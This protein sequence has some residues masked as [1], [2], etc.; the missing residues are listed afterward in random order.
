[1][2]LK[3]TKSFRLLNNKSALPNSTTVEFTFSFH[4]ISFF[5]I[6]LLPNFPLFFFL[7]LVLHL[8][9]GKKRREKTIAIIFGFKI[10]IFIW[11]LRNCA[12]GENPVGILSFVSSIL[13]SSEF[14]VCLLK[15]WERKEEL[16]WVHAIFSS[17]SRNWFAN[18]KQKQNKK[19]VI[20][21][22]KFDLQYE[23]RKIEN[24][25]CGY[26]ILKS[27]EVRWPRLVFDSK[28]LR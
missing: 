20:Q 10:Q 28:S 18:T 8:F 4:L 2:C 19:T 6:S 21:K 14:C 23:G 3:D 27:T 7:I 24:N 22:V 15:F 1:M 13:S 26:V 25:W 11:V 5:W 12:K 17:V 9:N 16:I